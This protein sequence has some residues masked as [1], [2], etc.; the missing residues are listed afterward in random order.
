MKLIAD[1]QAEQDDLPEDWTWIQTDIISRSRW[2]VHERE[3]YRTRDGYYFLDW[4]LRSSGDGIGG[5]GR[6]LVNHGTA[7]QEKVIT[8]IPTDEPQ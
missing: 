7:R 3:S 5:E 8:Y 1:A 4:E 2:G 6:E